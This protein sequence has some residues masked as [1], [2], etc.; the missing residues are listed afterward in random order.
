MKL[1]YKLLKWSWAKH[2]CNNYNGEWSLES[3]FVEMEM[4]KRMRTERMEKISVA[5]ISMLTGVGVWSYA[6]VYEEYETRKP[7]HPPPTHRHSQTNTLLSGSRALSLSDQCTSS[8]RTI[9]NVFIKMWDH[10]SSQVNRF[11]IR[12]LANGCFLKDF[13]TFA[14][15]KNT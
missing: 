4:K 11:W 13:Y 1:L 2:R 8:A 9:H 6:D 15:S 10:H 14:L 3:G 5:H 7:L 12:E